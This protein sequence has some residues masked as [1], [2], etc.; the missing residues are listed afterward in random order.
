MRW[1]KKKW[2]IKHFRHFEGKLDEEKE[3]WLFFYYFFKEYCIGRKSVVWVVSGYRE[4]L[5]K[6]L[7]AINFRENE[8]Y[9]RD[10]TI[11]VNFRVNRW[12]QSL[13]FWILIRKLIYVIENSSLWI[14]FNRLSFRTSFFALT[15]CLN[16]FDTN[17]IFWLPIHHFGLKLNYFH[18]ILFL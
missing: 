10:Q 1:V 13:S 8:L 11:L 3:Y 18:E 17:L 16:Y 4:L 6:R 5:M 7:H 12:K 9:P 15:T 14:K 2:R